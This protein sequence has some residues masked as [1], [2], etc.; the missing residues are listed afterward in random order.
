[1][2]RIY[3]LDIKGTNTANI[4]NTLE[5]I[6]NIK[7]IK[8]PEEIKDKKPNIVL[9]GNGSFGYYVN[10]LRQNQWELKLKEI[11]NNESS[12]KL[13][14]I[15]SGFQVLGFSSEESIGIKG[16][17]LI[18]CTFKSLNNYF[19]HPLIINIGRKSIYE[20]SNSTRLKDLNF[21]KKQNISN[22][23]NPYFVHGYAAKFK[24]PLKKKE[25]KCCY[26]INMINNEELLAGII[27]NNFCATQFHP[28]LSGKLWKDFIISFFNQK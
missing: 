16:L 14:C 3:I 17:G 20:S 26:L 13:F 22:L 11:I 15:C 10:F 7:T 24:N 21:I 5:N 27:S 19:N 28:E 23:M 18:D 6:F 12:G 2:E 25:K 8:T 4:T 1:M 9:P